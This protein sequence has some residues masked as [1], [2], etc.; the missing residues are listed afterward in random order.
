MG[1]YL[2]DRKTKFNMS[3]IK[4]IFKDKSLKLKKGYIQ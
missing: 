3:K 4:K 1:V 2:Y